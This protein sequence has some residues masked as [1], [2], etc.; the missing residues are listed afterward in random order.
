[1]AVEKNNK[2]T[3][4]YEG[5]FESGEVFDS[6]E[7]AG[8]PLEFVTGLGMVV[9]GFE[10]AVIGMEKNEEKTVEITPDKAYGYYKEELKKEIPRKLLPPD[11]EPKEGMILIMKGPNNM[12]FPSRI[13][14]VTDENLTVDLNHPLAGKKLIFKIKLLNYEKFD[15]K[16]FAKN[17]PCTCHPDTGEECKCDE[18]GDCNHNSKNH[19]KTKDKKESSIEDLAEG[20]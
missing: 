17:N 11:Q 13:I 15:P 2:V 7:K 3:V 16:Q 1:M 8:R 20:K 9:P 10:Q 12:Q 4:E 18:N 6:S 19:K 5:R 14:K